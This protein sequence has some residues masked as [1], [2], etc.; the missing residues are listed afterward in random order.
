[1]H[2]LLHTDVGKDRFDNAEPS[3]VDQLSLIGIDLCLHLIDQV[4]RLRIHWDG[5]I[6]ARCGWLAQT[7]CLQRTGGAVF[8]AGMVGIIGSITV[9]LVAGMAG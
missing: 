1:M 9:G 5:K 2:A 4:R 6:P 7:A 8:H 3:G